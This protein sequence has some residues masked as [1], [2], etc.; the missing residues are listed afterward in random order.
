MA[1][2][3]AERVLGKSDW[4]TGTRKIFLRESHD[5]VLEET[6]EKRL[7]RQVLVL[8]RSTRRYI[9]HRHYNRI[10]T[11]A[12]LIQKTWRGYIA[13]KTFMTVRRGFVRLQATIKSHIL[14]AKFQQWRQEKQRN[15]LRK[16]EEEKKREE[17]RKRAAEL[18]RLFTNRRK[19][20]ESIKIKEMNSN[21]GRSLAGNAEPPG[22][23]FG[24]GSIDQNTES[25]K[26]FDFQSIS[27]Y[28]QPFSE[29]SLYS[30]PGG[31]GHHCG[32]GSWRVPPL[33]SDAARLSGNAFRTTEISDTAFGLT[34]LILGL[35]FQSSDA[36]NGNTSR[37]FERT[38]V[39]EQESFVS[40]LRMR[41]KGPQLVHRVGSTGSQFSEHRGSRK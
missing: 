23:R 31:V 37:I 32:T 30:L 26:G 5:E 27:N 2:A 38:S 28:R 4:T 20:N 11:S 3:I 14:S 25:Q 34:S 18:G 33:T 6:R 13:R 9:R 22:M 8:Q 12:V 17:E 36:T 39:G 21:E 35:A 1:E 19:D 15:E 7:L 40:P 16:A 24:R 29:S 10:R 41:A